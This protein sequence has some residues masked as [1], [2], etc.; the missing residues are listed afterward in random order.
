M[1]TFEFKLQTPAHLNFIQNFDGLISLKAEILQIPPKAQIVSWS[2]WQTFD[3]APLTG[4][5]WHAAADSVRL[6][7]TTEGQLWVESHGSDVVS[8]KLD[9]S[10]TAGALS[11]APWVASRSRCGPLA[12]NGE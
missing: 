3:P 1:I 9:P 11:P 8:G 7:I 4:R 5:V 6:N 10:G 12:G 2:C